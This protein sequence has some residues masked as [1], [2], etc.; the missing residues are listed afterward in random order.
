M[1]FLCGSSAVVS[2]GTT[3]CGPCA[4]LAPEL[5]TLAAA[6]EDIPSLEDLDIAKVDA[7]EASSL[8]SRHGVGAYPTTLWM[9]EG[10]EVHRMEGAAPAAALV[11]LT[12]MHLLTAEEEEILRALAPEHFVPVP[13]DPAQAYTPAEHSRRSFRFFFFK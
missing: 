5:A 2:F 9:R 13:L 12:A 6:L 4:V 8:A 1:S 11:Q 3:W 10:R 7:E